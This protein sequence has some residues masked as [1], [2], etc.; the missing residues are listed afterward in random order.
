MT[1]IHRLSGAGT[2]SNELSPL[3]MVLRSSLAKLGL[4]PVSGLA[5]FFGAGLTIRAVGED[6]YGAISVYTAFIVMMPFLD[7]GMGAAIVDAIS[8]DG[9]NP[10]T[11]NMVR[12][13]R[14]RLVGVA[15]VVV[16]VGIALS[17]TDAWSTL[18]GSGTEATGSSARTGLIFTL[19]F[20][21]SIPLAV[22]GRILLAIGRQPAALTSAALGSVAAAMLIWAFSIA[23]A[24]PELY[25]A[26][27]PTGMCIGAAF[28]AVIAGRYCR[29][30]MAVE[31]QRGSARR[32]VRRV[33]LPMFVVMVCLPLALHS[34]RIILSH[35]SRSSSLNEYALMNQIYLPLYGVLTAGFNTL[36]P[37]FNR[38]RALG[39]PLV[40][41]WQASMGFA[42]GAALLVAAGIALFAPYIAGIVSD[43]TIELPGMLLA[44]TVA[45]L[46]VQVL[47]Y[48]SAMALM[49]SSSLRLQAGMSI[50]V[51]IL[52]VPL[53][54][55]L[56]H[57][58]GSWGPVAASAVVMLSVQA[59]PTMLVARRRVTAV[60]TE[61]ME[62]LVPRKPMADSDH[63]A[64]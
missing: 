32:P 44:S 59:I 14:A 31:T 48:P 55:L 47:H 27:V 42:V 21:P 60:E 38:K 37:S 3:S 46:I 17:A 56:A 10:T 12:S 50:L 24:P 49:D 40:A 25:V 61:Q 11:M 39:E 41:L 1:R 4:T 54:L 63:L 26:A 28:S 20:A 16:L 52:N 23:D 8:H 35:V 9:V 34:D 18:L 36:W 33:A 29:Q 2:G 62:V 58:Y 19:C 53:S 5:A 15:G 51:L 6:A 13:V 22:S 45:L 64:P 43:G 57:R 30:L 7:F